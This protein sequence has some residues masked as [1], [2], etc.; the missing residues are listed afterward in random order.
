V[1]NTAY[2]LGTWSGKHS[3]YFSHTNWRTQRIC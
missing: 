1:A 2:I 3:L